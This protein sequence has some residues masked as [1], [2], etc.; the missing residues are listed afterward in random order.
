MGDVYKTA[1]GTWVHKNLSLSDS[2][3]V[4]LTTLKN[5]PPAYGHARV[6]KVYFQ[7][8][9]KYAIETSDAGPNTM[10]DF[11]GIAEA[12]NDERNLKSLLLTLFSMSQYVNH[13]GVWQGDFKPRNIGV[14]KRRG[15]G[16]LRFTLFDYDKAAM[17]G[18]KAAIGGEI[19][20]QSGLFDK[21]EYEPGYTSYKLS[22]EALVKELEKTLKIPGLADRADALW[23]EIID[24]ARRTG[25]MEGPYDRTYIEEPEPALEMRVG[26]HARRLPHQKWLEDD[27]WLQQY[28]DAADENARKRNRPVHGR[29]MY[30]LA[31]FGRNR[32]KDKAGYNPSKLREK[33]ERRQTLP[34][35]WRCI[36]KRDG[37]VVRFQAHVKKSNC[38]DP[39]PP[40][41]SSSSTIVHNP[42][43]PKPAKTPKARS[44]VLVSGGRRRKI[45]IK[46]PRAEREK[47]ANVEVRPSNIPGAGDGLF[48]KAPFKEDDVV[49]TYGGVLMLNSTAQAKPSETRWS[50]IYEVPTLHGEDGDY[51]KLDPIM[52]LDGFSG[53]NYGHMAHKANDPHGGYG[54][55]AYKGREMVP[56]NES[57][58]NVEMQ[59]SYDDQYHVVA[60][61]VALRDIKAGEEIYLQ[62]GRD[63]WKSDG[64]GKGTSSG[65]GGAS[66][67]APA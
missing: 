58:A 18:D 16:T 23:D 42:P 7:K 1:D 37:T 19:V 66:K 17:L 4:A 35:Q 8:S 39:P 53:G 10:A 44:G 46:A 34:K 49:A 43:P 32:Y 54:D 3:K 25:R 45:T 55:N 2:T 52:A 41:S 11:P 33:F 21:R 61:L 5:N 60:Y 51:I 14:Q 13:Y 26:T 24:M 50:Y 62:Y 57:L 64:G 20:R 47:N 31:R 59:W 65:G 6:L 30:E 27:E 56:D 22:G 38:P 28:F 63:Y 48:A 15:D 29:P 40:S 67:D 12:L 36:T 9:G